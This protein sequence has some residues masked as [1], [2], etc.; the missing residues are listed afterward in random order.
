MFEDI[1]GPSAMWQAS[2][3]GRSYPEHRHRQAPSMPPARPLGAQVCVSLS[4]G[5][6]SVADSRRGFLQIVSGLGVGSEVDSGAGSEYIYGVCVVY[7]WP[8]GNVW[9]Y[10]QNC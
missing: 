2:Y 10:A 4:V 3:L 9:K 6:M 1:Y 5:P 8:C 7:V